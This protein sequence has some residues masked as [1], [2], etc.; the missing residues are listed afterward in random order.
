VRYEKFDSLTFPFNSR[1]VFVVQWQTIQP[2]PGFSI[3]HLLKI[4]DPTAVL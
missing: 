2:T 3:A 4:L 1:G